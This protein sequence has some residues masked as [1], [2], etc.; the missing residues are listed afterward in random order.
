MANLEPTRFND[1]VI[2]ENRWRSVEGPRHPILVSKGS[3]SDSRTPNGERS[4]KRCSVTIWSR[5][6]G[7][8]FPSGSETL[9]LPM[10]ARSLRS[11]S[12]ARLYVPSAEAPRT[13]NGGDW[14]RPYDGQ[15]RGDANEPKTRNHAG[16]NPNPFTVHG[17]GATSVERG[18]DRCSWGFLR[19]R[20]R[21]DGL[22]TP[23]SGAARP[24]AWPRRA[25]PLESHQSSLLFLNGTVSAR[26][27]NPMNGVALSI[28]GR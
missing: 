1:I 15:L 11:R 7:L 12:H 16:V 28:R 14:Q 27:W 19:G 9:S 2:S 13:G 8:R 24:L 3:T 23:R 5:A 26:F 4:S 10:R 22:A 20:F 21:A 25:R 6:A 17:S 18:D